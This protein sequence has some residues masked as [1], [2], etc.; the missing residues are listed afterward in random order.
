MAPFFFAKNLD[1][2]F[3]WRWFIMT[4]KISKLIVAF[5]L[6]T[7]LGLTFG[8]VANNNFSDDSASVLE[9]T[10]EMAHEPYEW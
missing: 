2:L 5:L 1:K 4:A 6:V 3:V 7:V 8:T 9:L 10:P